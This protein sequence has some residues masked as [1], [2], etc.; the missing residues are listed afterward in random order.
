MIKQI[1]QR[2][3]DFKIRKLITGE[4][5]EEYPEATDL[6]V[7]SKC[8]SKWLLVDLET[9]QMY[10]GMKDPGPYGKWRRLKKR[11]KINESND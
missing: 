9:G 8:P 7:H 10:R 11:F 6:T 4:E 1:Q 3:Q 2:I 5:S